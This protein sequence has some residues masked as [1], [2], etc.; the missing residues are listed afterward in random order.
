MWSGYQFSWSFR[1]KKILKLMRQNNGDAF[2]SSKLLVEEGEW[3]SCLA[4][5]TARQG[6]AWSQLEHVLL[7]SW[8]SSLGSIYWF[9]QTKSMSRKSFLFLKRQLESS[10]ATL[11]DF[12][13]I[14]NISQSHFHF[15]DS[16]KAVLERG[17]TLNSSCWFF[18]TL[19]K[20]I[21]MRQGV[22]DITQTIGSCNHR[23][24]F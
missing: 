10:D 2:S 5:L 7:S 19:K 6:E 16:K 17:N 13:C 11:G 3:C 20:T 9:L 14:F 15:S 4:V 24:S 18:S 22:A 12:G 1:K 21:K 8:N 23:T